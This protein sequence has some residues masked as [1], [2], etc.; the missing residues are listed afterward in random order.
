VND[1]YQTNDIII[2]SS[3]PT[4]GSLLKS[5]NPFGFTNAAYAGKTFR[6]L[7]MGETP[8]SNC[9]TTASGSPPTQLPSLH[10]CTLKQ[11]LIGKA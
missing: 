3:T 10:P 2:F 4:H 5:G 1:D 11:C 9:L 7:L 6:Q 8:I